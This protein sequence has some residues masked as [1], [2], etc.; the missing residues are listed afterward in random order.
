[1]ATAQEISSLSFLVII[2]ELYKYIHRKVTIVEQGSN[3][4]ISGPWTSEAVWNG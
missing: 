3:V 2:E 1:M 4:S